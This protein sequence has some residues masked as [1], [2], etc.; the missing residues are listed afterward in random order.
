MS[1]RTDAQS[2]T[3]WFGAPA[4]PHCGGDQ[5]LTT[6]VHGHWAT[7]CVPCGNDAL[8]DRVSP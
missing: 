6:E 1:N 8:A 7:Y 2:K 4:C 5:R 3:Y